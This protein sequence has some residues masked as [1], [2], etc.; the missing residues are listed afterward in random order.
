[1]S[2]RRLRRVAIAG[3]FLAASTSWAGCV[4]VS[5]LTG[6]NMA[7][8]EF[9]SKRLPG[10]MYKDY[11]YPT[12]QDLGYFASKGATVIRLPFRWERAQP[13]LM[14][15]L[16]AA[17]MSAIAKVVAAAVPLGLCVILD[18][19]NYG[20]YHGKTIGSAEV[21]T[22]AFFDFWTKMAQRFP[23]ASQV[24][25]GLMNEP[26]ALPIPQWAEVARGTV[27]AL[28]EAG[29]DNLILV[30]GG[31]WSGVHEWFKQFSGTSN[32]QAFAD[33]PDP[34]GRTLIEVHQ[35]ANL[36]YSGTTTD[37]L[38]PSH[39]DRMFASI[40]DWARANGYK[41]FLGEFGTPGTAEC[42]A[43]LDR[44]LAL[45]SNRDVW[46]GWAVWAA[47]RWWGSYPL[48]IHPKDGVD[49]PQMSVVPPYLG[50]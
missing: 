45:G 3:S 15:A 22:A 5:P 31:R 46:R 10:T 47:G 25:F 6:V 7:G 27:A 11:V 33:L 43:T 29:A 42:L 4:D 2:I 30:A 26:K 41:L 40:S 49:A 36:G 44:L 23:D 37:C 1:M 35:Y 21:P 17:Q 32:A 16:D 38:P 8:A 18:A 20:T 24:A 28:R 34:L 19:H 39:F 13:S 12:A 14:E 48:S 50:K 9:N